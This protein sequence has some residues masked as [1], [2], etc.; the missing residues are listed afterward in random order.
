MI[1]M[2]HQDKRW[3]I[4]CYIIYQKDCFQE[5][6]INFLGGYIAKFLSWWNFRTA[7]ILQKIYLELVGFPFM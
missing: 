1:F 2:S 7:Q 5:Q 4:A 6:L 3:I